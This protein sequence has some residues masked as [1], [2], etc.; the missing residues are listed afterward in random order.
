MNHTERMKLWTCAA[1]IVSTIALMPYVAYA[2]KISTFTR[3]LPPSPLP[4]GVAAN[5]HGRAQI[6]LE[7]GIRER[8]KLD[9]DDVEVIGNPADPAFCRGFYAAVLSDLTRTSEFPLPAF[10]G[11][12]VACLVA[13]D[14]QGPTRGFLNFDVRLNKGATAINPRGLLLSIWEVEPVRDPVTRAVIHGPNGEPFIIDRRVAVAV[15][16]ILQ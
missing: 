1:L 10:P 13:N 14:P 4:A 2:V 11:I 6:E 5:G 3:L 7:P 9:V 16:G 12:V 15:H 8:L